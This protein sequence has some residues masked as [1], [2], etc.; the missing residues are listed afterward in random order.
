MSDHPEQELASAPELTTHEAVYEELKPHE[1]AFE[2]M[3]RLDGPL[4]DRARAALVY[5]R[6]HE[7]TRQ[8]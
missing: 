1:P 6:V 7:R 8:S 3:A 2:R 4:S 5:I